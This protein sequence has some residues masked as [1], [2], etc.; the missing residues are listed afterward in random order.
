MVLIIVLIILG[1]L[2]IFFILRLK[3][4]NS[5]YKRTQLSLERVKINEQILK[6]WLL[7]KQM[8]IRICDW[9][10]DNNI[11]NIAIYGFG[12][13][14]QALYNE[15]KRDSIECSYIIDKNY[16]NIVCEAKTI[17]LDD[18][19]ELD[20][21]AIIIS[22]INYYDEIESEIMKRCKLPIISLEDIIYGVGI[23]DDKQ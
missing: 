12:D 23:N 8:D 4:V 3:N 10:R 6:E 7:L 16:F 22:V 14:G 17:G 2:D 13:L 5:Q 11:H 18:I 20:V 9:L 19:Y 1:I 21:D 15:V